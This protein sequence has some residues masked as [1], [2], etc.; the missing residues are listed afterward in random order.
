LLGF[1]TIPE[2]LSKSQ[3]QPIIDKI[4]DQLPGCKAD[5]MRRVW[6]KV[7]VQ[8]VLTGMIIYLAMVVDLST[9]AWKKRG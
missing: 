9:L 6:Q 4:A 1:A 3:V 7:Q 5:L 2:K 8:F